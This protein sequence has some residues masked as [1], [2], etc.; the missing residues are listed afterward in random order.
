MGLETSESKRLNLGI[1][2]CPQKLGHID[3]DKARK[4]AILNG[5]ELH[6]DLHMASFHGNKIEIA[7]WPLIAIIYPSPEKS[8]YGRFADRVHLVPARKI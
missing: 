4:L 3:W 1:F 2:T 6:P 5:Y 7:K 8:G